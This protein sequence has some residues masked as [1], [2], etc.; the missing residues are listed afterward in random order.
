MS[1]HIILNHILNG[2]CLWYVVIGNFS[3]SLRYYSSVAKG[4]Q[5]HLCI[6]KQHP[7]VR[8]LC[9][10]VFENNIAILEE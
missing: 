4:S 3:F 5:H 6:L 1:A 10:L 2:G 7:I 8:G 9:S